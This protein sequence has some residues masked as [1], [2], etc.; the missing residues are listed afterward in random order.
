MP[1]CVFRM[2]Q[3]DTSPWR[4]VEQPH[5]ICTCEYVF[6][7]ETNRVGLD[8]APPQFKKFDAS[9]IS[10]TARMKASAVRQFV[11]NSV[12]NCPECGSDVQELIPKKSPLMESKTSLRSMLYVLENQVLFFSH[13]KQIVPTLRT[14]HKCPGL[15][16]VVRVDTGA[17]P[18]MLRGANVMAAGVQAIPDGVAVGDF[19][20]VV[21]AGHSLAVCVGALEQPRRDVLSKRAGSAV[22]TFHFLGDGLWELRL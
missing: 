16:P 15:L 17:T 12:K 10:S 13:F 22:R 20:Q 11:Q 3:A 9:F 4:C 8:M 21:P 7:F 1:H 18:F 19:V 2:D 6:C 14:L 5:A